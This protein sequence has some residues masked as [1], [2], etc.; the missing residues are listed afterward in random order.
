MSS[1]FRSD[2]V[3]RLAGVRDL[4]KILETTVKEMGDIFQADCCQIM[5]SNPLDPNVTSICEFR[6]AP[7]EDGRGHPGVTM[8]LVLHGRTFGSLSMSRRAE[9]SQ[10]EVNSMRVILGELGDI[11]RHAQI[12][13]IVQRDTFRDTFLV[14]I[15]NVMAY[16]LGIGDA[17]FMVVNILGKVLQASRCLFVC[18]DDSAAGWKCYEFWQQEKVQ[19]CQEYRWPT[20]DSPVIAQTLLSTA[21][22]RV[23]EGQQNSYVSPVQEELQFIGVKSLLGISLR[24]SAAT[25]GCVILQQCDYRRAWTRNE[26]DMVQK[27]ADKVADALVKLPAE[28]R[29]REPIMQLHQRIVAVPDA[30]AQ[31]GKTSYDSVRKA[32]KGAL[33]QQA[34]PS[35]RATSAPPPPPK[36]VAPP[37]PQPVP[38][39]AP[40]PA[41]TQPPVPPMPTSQ[42]AAQQGFAPAAQ[43]NP[44]AVG[45]PTIS[46]VQSRSLPPAVE[47]GSRSLGSILGGQSAPL[48]A[49]QQPPVAAPGPTARGTAED[50]YADLDFG[51]FGEATLEQQQAAAAAGRPIPGRPGLDQQMDPDAT[52]GNLDAI[53]P[54]IGQSLA[55]EPPMTAAQARMLTDTG[56]QQPFVPNPSTPPA[57]TP[58]H[59]GPETTQPMAAPFASA[60]APLPVPVAASVAEAAPASGSP[61]GDLDSIAAPTTGPAKMGLGGAIMSKVRA[62]APAAGSALMA[63]F[64]KDK[65]KYG[66][67]EAL[68]EVTAASAPPPPL[69]DAAA[70]AKIHELMQSKTTETSDYI[71]AT[72]GLDMRMLGRIDGWV[73]QIEQ[74]DKYADGHAR[75]V[76]ELACA[77]AREAGLSAADVDLVRQA[78]LVHD[79]GKLG[80]AAAILQKPDEQL[81]DPELITV[82][83]HPLDGAEL[84][85]SFPDLQRLAPIVR[86]HHEEYNGNGY[87]Q[88]LKGEEIPVAARIIHVAN[89]YHGMTSAKRFG[90]GMKPGDAQQ[91]LVK[92]AGQQW[93]PT[94]V[95]MLIQAIMSNK[96]PAAY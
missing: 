9:V 59:V 91:E 3:Q 23:Y 53:Q 61:W 66:P 35:A 89:S 44:G 13:D 47:P 76:A 39:S 20:T 88:G 92:G 70:Q 93:D 41:L 68:P 25:H 40:Q 52:W 28:K 55:P 38:P 12:N 81:S 5:L 34:I 42:P 58:P 72:P 22:L 21:P 14:E 2:F 78:S 32:L 84:L 49:V 26:V 94:F 45:G 71:F 30:P 24:S 87:P 27:V 57:S 65:A 80:S 63:S 96:V 69:D 31:D 37:P 36:P 43:V 50:P 48:P 75:Q 54:P 10:E 16:S 60:P 19:S 7:D 4:K 95:Q 51:D 82:M 29:A 11:V 1:D 18:T 74:K 64:H 15:G 79:V 86:A 6:A 83:K 90:P 85:E 73:S 33:G 77:I 62:V 8:P 46:P 56:P 17:L 67:A